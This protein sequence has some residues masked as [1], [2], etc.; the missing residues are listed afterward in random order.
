MKKKL[1]MVLLSA[2]TLQAYAST[3]ETKAAIQKAHEQSKAIEKHLKNKVEDAKEKSN[4]AKAKK[5]QS[6]TNAKDMSKML[7]ALKKAHKMQAKVTKH[8]G[9]SAK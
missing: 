3:E 7:A 2:L 8:L 1:I 6:K 5:D 9:N 4:E